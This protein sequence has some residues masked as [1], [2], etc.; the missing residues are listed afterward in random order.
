MTILVLILA[1]F[2]SISVINHQHTEHKCPPEVEHTH[3]P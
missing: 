1:T 2:F 3:L